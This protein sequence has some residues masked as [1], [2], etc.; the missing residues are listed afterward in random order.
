MCK[1][2]NELEFVEVSEDIKHVE[3]IV[4][5]RY[6]GSDRG[7]RYRR[8]VRNRVMRRKK[9]IVVDKFGREHFEMGYGSEMIG[10]LSKGKIHCSCGMCTEKVSNLGFKYSDRRKMLD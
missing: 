2:G 8:M 5:A 3:E 9:R 7:R 4:E 10:K 1:S 6:L